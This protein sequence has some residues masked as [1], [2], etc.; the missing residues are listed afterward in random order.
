MDVQVNS[1]KELRQLQRENSSGLLKLQ[2]ENSSRLLQ[3]LDSQNKEIASQNK[4]LS[5]QNKEIASQNKQLSSLLS[6]MRSEREEARL[7]MESQAKGISSLL[8]SPRS[9][10]LMEE[11]EHR[12]SR[13]V[14]SHKTSTLGTVHEIS[15]T[16]TKRGRRIPSRDRAACASS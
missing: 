16:V 11:R 6:L 15:V 8:S 14:R 3:R 2:R 9:E 1:E 12:V 4:Q 5:S 13:V 7:R 10:G